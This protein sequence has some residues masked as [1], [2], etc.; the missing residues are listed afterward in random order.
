MTSRLIEECLDYENLHLLPDEMYINI[1]ADTMLIV[2]DPYAINTKDLLNCK[3]RSMNIIRIR[4]PFW[5]QGDVRKYIQLIR[6]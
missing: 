6:R 5:G 1:P 3:R 2:V 4:R